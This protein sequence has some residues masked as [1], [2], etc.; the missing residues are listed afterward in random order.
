M[1]EDIAVEVNA[2][3]VGAAESRPA[4]AGWYP[5]PGAAPG[6]RQVRFWDGTEWL[7]SPRAAGLDG[8]SPRDTLGRVALILLGTG[9]FATIGVPLLDGLVVSA[10]SYSGASL[11]GIMLVIL[12]L[13][14]LAV[15]V[16]I[17]GLVRAHDSAF[18]APLSLA[19]LIISALGTVLVVLPIA[20]FATG[21]W[22]IHI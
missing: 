16:S 22:S 1:S 8:N 15:V 12:A 9:F 5:L 19:S 21:V 11:G 18:K 13:T 14:P 17:T 2:A 10:T 7:G 4:P 3:G 20:L 6:T